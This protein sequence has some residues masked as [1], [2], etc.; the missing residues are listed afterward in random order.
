M[1][2][3][4]NKETGINELFRNHTLSRLLDYKRNKNAKWSFYSQEL[5]NIGIDLIVR[6]ETAKYLELCVQATE[7]EHTFTI[8]HIKPRSNYWF[9]FFCGEI[10]TEIGE[11]IFDYYL[12]SSQEVVDN[13]RGKHIT[14]DDSMRKYKHRSFDCMGPTAK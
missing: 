1:V 5:D 11:P 2:S 14:M 7:S 10:D 8:E 12:L 13:M 9:I 6:T 3:E 4:M